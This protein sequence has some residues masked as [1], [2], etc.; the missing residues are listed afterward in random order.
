MRPGRSED[1]LKLKDFLK[2]QFGMR[3]VSQLFFYTT[4]KE[5]AHVKSQ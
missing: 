4:K 3:I 5:P 2:Y 1:L